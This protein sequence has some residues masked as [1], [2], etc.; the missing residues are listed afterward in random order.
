MPFCSGFWSHSA[1][2][3]ERIEKRKGAWQRW[4]ACT[5][6][7]RVFVFN[8]NVINIRKHAIKTKTHPDSASRSMP[9]PK[10]LERVH[11][12]KS[13]PD[14]SISTQQPILLQEQLF[15][16]NRPFHSYRF[17][18]DPTR[19]SFFLINSWPWLI[20]EKEELWDEEKAFVLTKRIETVYPGG[21]PTSSQ[22]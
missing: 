6:R 10:I 19:I 11:H 21:R 2:V 8:K 20:L 5:G 18:F 13:I 22:P 12:A 16:S 17:P 14:R 9:G 1:R 15:T 3:D 4:W 7:I